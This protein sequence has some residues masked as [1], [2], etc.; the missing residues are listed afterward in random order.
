MTKDYAKSRP[1]LQ[2]RRRNRYQPLTPSSRGFPSWAWALLGIVC[3]VGLSF[4]FFSKMNT[5]ALSESSV[6]SHGSKSETVSSLKKP[7]K[8]YQEF[9]KKNK[10]SPK[11]KEQSAVVKAL[12]PIKPASAPESRFDFYTLLPTMSVDPLSSETGH[13]AKKNAIPYIL[14]AGS[15]KTHEQADQLRAAL[16]LQGFEARIQFVHINAAES[17]YRVY[18]GPFN[19]KADA[20]EMQQNLE[21]GPATLERFNSVILKMRIT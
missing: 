19:T 9:T 18:M 11:G 3:G 16:A 13:A 5:N 17:W 20:L 10:S 4:L 12:T 6:V 7:S 21:N 1:R 8:P 2:S 14:Q 15:F